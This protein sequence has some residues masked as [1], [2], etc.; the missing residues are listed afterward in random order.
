MDLINDR[1]TLERLDQFIRLEATGSPDKLAEKMNTSRRTL[2]RIIESL[3]DLG[4]PIYYNRSKNSYCYKYPGKLIIKFE[5]ILFDNDELSKINGGC[6]T[7]FRRVPTRDTQRL[8]F[9]TV[10]Q[11]A[12][13]L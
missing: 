11:N 12:F 3:K 13:V 8:Y 6:S 1:Q 9:C 5:N 7:F 10:K 4:C 2:F